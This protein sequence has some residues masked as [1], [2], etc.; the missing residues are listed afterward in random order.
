MFRVYVNVL[1][2]NDIKNIQYQ[3]KLV[4]NIDL[5]YYYHFVEFIY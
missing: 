2:L 5:A 4:N 1:L 3:Y